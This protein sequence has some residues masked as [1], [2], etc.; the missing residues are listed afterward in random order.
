M[1]VVLVVICFG[2]VDVCVFV[3]GFV[4]FWISGLPVFGLFSVRV[5]V[6]RVV[7]D[8]CGLDIWYLLC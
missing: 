7:Y 1:G 5:G 8:S 3:G 6:L 4:G 2:F